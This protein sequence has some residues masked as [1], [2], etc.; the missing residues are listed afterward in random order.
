MTRKA[1]THSDSRAEPMAQKEK[2]GLLDIEEAPIM[3]HCFAQKQVM[4]I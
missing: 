3:W 1:I 2:G 4:M